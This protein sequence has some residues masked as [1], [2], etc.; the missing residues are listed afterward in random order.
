[1][2][3]AMTKRFIKKIFPLLA[4]L[5]L[6]PWPAAYAYSYNSEM[7]GQGVVQI[8]VAEASVAPSATVFGRGIGGVTPG[9]LFYID[10]EDYPA[11]I[12][13]ALHL[14]NTQALSHCYR[15]MTL[16][17]EVYIQ[18]D[19]NEWVKATWW[20]GGPIP[21]TYITLF[22]GQVSFVLPGYAKYKV[23]IDGGCFYCITT[24]TDGGS[25]SPQFYLSV[26]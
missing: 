14:T 11:D 24:N 1:M 23:T 22:N 18:T 12:M 3:S 9:D 5:L 6:A 7:T 16:K 17:V 13:V 21:D 20:D 2:R 25:V 10:T 4:I 15:Y 26:D 19:T 8:E